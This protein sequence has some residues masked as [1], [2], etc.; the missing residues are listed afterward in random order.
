MG[1]GF[2]CLFI[3]FLASALLYFHGRAEVYITTYHITQT[4]L[5]VS[6][7]VV[8]HFMSLW[9]DIDEFRDDVISGGFQF[10][11]LVVATLSLCG[12]WGDTTPRS[13]D[14][15]LLLIFSAMGAHWLL[16][17]GK[18]FIQEI[19]YRLDG[20]KTHLKVYDSMRS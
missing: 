15:V 18:G 9:A 1:F 17:A 2:A 10:I 19:R 11:A 4:M 20:G 8:E 12:M 16:R 5:N 14:H 6:G 13:I 3:L 7:S